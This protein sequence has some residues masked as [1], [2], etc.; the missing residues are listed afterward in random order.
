MLLEFSFDLFHPLDN[1]EIYNWM[2]LLESDTPSQCTK[3]LTSRIFMITPIQFQILCQKTWKYAATVMLVTV[4]RCWWQNL[5]DIFW[6]LKYKVLVTKAAKSVANI[7][8]AKSVP[9]WSRIG[10]S[11]IITVRDSTGWVNLDILWSY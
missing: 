7:I 4:F 10:L 8:V 9:I 6:I 2:F 3:Y 5:R 11:L 1:N